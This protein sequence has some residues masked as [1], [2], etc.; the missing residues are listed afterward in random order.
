MGAN[1]AGLELLF[2]AIKPSS[3]MKSITIGKEAYGVSYWIGIIF[4]VPI[5]AIQALRKGQTGR[6]GVDLKE[7]RLE[8]K[9][10]F[11]SLYFQAPL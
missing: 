11:F 9:A 7:K 4:W 3:F 2:V 10:L 6:E 8:F 5:H 1:S